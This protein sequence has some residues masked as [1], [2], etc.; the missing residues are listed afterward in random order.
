MPK[1]AA[2]QK[3]K[4]KTDLIVI[5]ARSERVMERGVRISPPRR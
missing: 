5:T 4:G 2:R 1:K 3:A